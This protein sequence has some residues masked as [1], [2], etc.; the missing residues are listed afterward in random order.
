[1]N[2]NTLYNNLQCPACALSDIDMHPT[3]VCEIDTTSTHDVR[4]GFWCEECKSIS[5]LHIKA[6]KGQTFLSI[7]PTGRKILLEEI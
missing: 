6:H 5:V 3:H 4:V 7:E 1:M 2:I